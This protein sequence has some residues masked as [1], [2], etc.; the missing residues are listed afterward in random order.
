[1]EYLFVRIHVYVENCESHNLITSHCTHEYVLGY[2]ELYRISSNTRFLQ[3]VIRP[4]V[5]CADYS[6]Y[7]GSKDAC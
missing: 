2:N 4:G 7:P 1:M 6:M 5:V 3:V